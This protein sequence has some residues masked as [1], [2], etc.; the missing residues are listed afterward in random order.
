MVTERY[1]DV[2]AKYISNKH[3]FYSI[4]VGSNKVSLRKFYWPKSQRA[5]II[6]LLLMKILDAMSSL[7]PQ[8]GTQYLQY[9]TYRD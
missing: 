4:R 9:S 3:L 7:A 8:R 1:N 2:K 6:D 5:H